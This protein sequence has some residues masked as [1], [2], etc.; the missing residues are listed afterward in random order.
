[1]KWNNVHHKQKWL[2]TTATVFALILFGAQSEN[3]DSRCDGY[4]CDLS[5]T[6]SSNFYDPSECDSF[7]CATT[8]LADRPEY[9]DLLTS[10]GTGTALRS[11]TPIYLPTTDWLSA[12]F[13]QQ[14]FKILAMEVLG[15]KTR[16]AAMADGWS[17]LCCDPTV[18]WLE[19]WPTDAF[20]T[21]L[22]GSMVSLPNGYVGYANLYVPNYVLDSYPLASA[23]SAY[24]YLP[25][26]KSIFPAAFS[27][28]CNETMI[29]PAGAC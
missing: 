15:F 17:V 29:D 21:D 4:T 1:M 7:T 23:Y 16:S 8:C 6:A 24:K 18:I 5:D 13:P 10:L 12:Q 28:H 14:I 9:E 27:T 26:Y 25:E 3:S 2:T 19:R 22:Q 11:N 20:P